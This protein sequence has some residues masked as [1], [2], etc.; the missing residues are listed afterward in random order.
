MYSFVQQIQLF[1]RR[2]ADLD[3]ETRRYKAESQRISS[4]IGRLQGEIQN[5]MFIKSSC[6]VEKLGLED[7]LATIKHTRKIFNHSFF[8]QKK[9]CFL[10]DEADLAELRSRNVS[11]D[12]DPS[13][14]F[15]NELATAIREIRNDYENAVE[16]QRTEM[17]NRYTLLYNELI[18]QQQRPDTSALY[19]EQQRRQE[20]RVRSEL[21]QTQNQSGYLRAQ[22]QDVRNRIDE[23]KR[24]IGA[25]REDGS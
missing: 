2:I 5:E 13:H 22:N 6:E 10:L 9:N 4:E 18:I 16:S 8:F 24:K 12:L 19:S 20:E 21:L 23:L 15:R 14:F 25:L 17:Q 1:R 3:D 7:E 11:T